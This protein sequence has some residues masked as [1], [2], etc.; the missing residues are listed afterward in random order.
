MSRFDFGRWAIFVIWVSVGLVSGAAS[1]RAQDT[2]PSSDADRPAALITGTEQGWR[3]MGPDE[4]VNVNC[5]EDTWEWTEE[6]LVCKGDC[7]GVMRSR[8]PKENFELML[9]WRH[10]QFAG[11]SGVFV[12]SPKESLDQLK[13]NSLPAGIE[14]QVLDLGYT[15]QYEKGTGRKADWFTTHGDVFPVGSSKMKPFPPVSPNGQRSFPSANHTRP[16]GQWNHYYIRCVNGEVRLWVNGHEVS[17]G[18]D[19][20]P[21]NG[22]IALESEGAPI[23]FRNIRIRELP[24]ANR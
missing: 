13:P 10:N 9:E 23:D 18:T 12:W 24:S 2:E 14:V 21:S 8:D 22:Y 19:C 15:E 11:N 1:S 5:N 6:M 7:V 20:Q 16:H 3:A 4:W 17:G